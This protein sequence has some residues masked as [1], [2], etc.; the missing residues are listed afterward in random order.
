MKA[1]LR[2]RL[3]ASNAKRTSRKRANQGK[4]WEAVLDA[5][6]YL[7]RS[8]GAAWII[9]TPPPVKVLSRVQGG[10]F[11]ACFEG[12]GPPDYAGVVRGVPVVFDAKSTADPGRW[13]L[14]EV[15]PHQ[16][17][18][19]DSAEA[20]GAFCFI[21]L[22][23]PSGSWVL[24]WSELGD[25]WRTWRLLSARGRAPAGSASLSAED[26]A[27]IGVPFGRDGWISCVPTNN[28]TA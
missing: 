26:I 17:A 25:H 6:H 10:M 24:P 3:A 5:M 20:C 28:G 23:H 9:R 27:A 19:L 7:Y 18:H 21:A 13:A 12:L 4:S 15:K 14:A 22:L 2:K 11:R 8:T 16:A 1:R